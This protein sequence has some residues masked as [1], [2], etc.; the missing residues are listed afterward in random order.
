LARRKSREDRIAS[1]RASQEVELA[2]EGDWLGRAQ[3]NAPASLQI[4][5]KPLREGI[6]P[7]ADLEDEFFAGFEESESDREP[8]APRRKR[9]TGQPED[10]AGCEWRWVEDW[11]WGLF[12]RTVALTPAE[13]R[14]EPS[15][16]GRVWGRVDITAE[17]FKRFGVGLEA[18]LQVAPRKWAAEQPTNGPWP[19][20]LQAMRQA[21][22]NPPAIIP[23][24]DKAEELDRLVRRLELLEEW[25]DRNSG[26][27]FER[28]ITHR[29]LGRYKKEALGSQTYARGVRHEEY[30][31]F[32]A[33]HTERRVQVLLL[34]GYKPSRALEA[35][36]FPKLERVETKLFPK[37]GLGAE[38]RLAAQALSERLTAVY[39]AQGN[40]IISCP[41]EWSTR[42]LSAI[43][44]K[45][46]ARGK[47]GRPP[48]GDKAMSD[49]ERKQR[50]RDKLRIFEGDKCH[51]SDQRAGDRND[52]QPRTG[53]LASVRTSEGMARARRA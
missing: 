8:E 5:L 44:K 25:T 39:L 26:P 1:Q 45:Y 50:Q 33:Q 32:L 40:A 30:A 28:G 24:Q 14:G 43:V 23:E 49:A 22:Q 52:G 4:P 29:R 37:E 20:L 47:R 53:G 36:R 31:D 3:T 9:K 10:I 41:S 7:Q 18:T 15:T 19:F 51:A 13:R 11:G 35:E 34:R 17:R 21:E 16:W 6:E 46:E 2:R 12:P 38:R 27:D 42:E 48:I